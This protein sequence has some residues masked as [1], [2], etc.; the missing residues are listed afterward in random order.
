MNGSSLISP[1]TAI[2]MRYPVMAMSST[3]AITDVITFLICFAR[4]MVD[5]DVDGRG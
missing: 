2:R 5:I 3:A 4:V 1:I